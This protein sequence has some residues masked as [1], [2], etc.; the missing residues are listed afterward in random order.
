MEDGEKK[1]MKRDEIIT[2]LERQ[3]YAGHHEVRKLEHPTR[4]YIKKVLGWTITI[5]RCHLHLMRCS[6]LDL[7]G[8]LGFKK[9]WVRNQNNFGTFSSRLTPVFMLILRYLFKKISYNHRWKLLITHWSAH[10]IAYIT[11]AIEPRTII[12]H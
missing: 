6:V 11:L 3:L 7:W 5:M 4:R 1:L 2:N 12:S 9:I 8:L 10:S